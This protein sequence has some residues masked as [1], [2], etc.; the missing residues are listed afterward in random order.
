MMMIIIRL[1]LYKSMRYNSFPCN[2][3]SFVLES[4]ILNLLMHISEHSTQEYKKKKKINE[5]EKKKLFL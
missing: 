1:N 4:K 5:Q 2:F 3:L